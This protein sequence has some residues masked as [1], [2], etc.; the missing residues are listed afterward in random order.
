MLAVQF[1]S[2]TGSTAGTFLVFLRETDNDHHRILNRHRHR[3]QHWPGCMQSQHMAPIII[4]VITALKLLK[5]HRLY[6][7]VA[8][9]Q[10]GFSMWWHMIQ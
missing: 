10:P 4:I 6:C 5:E 2:L 3:L 9:T 1:Y 8:G 7:S